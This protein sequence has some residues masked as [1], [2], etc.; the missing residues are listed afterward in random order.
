MRN[1]RNASASIILCSF[2]LWGC[3][4]TSI[5][6][7][8]ASPVTEKPPETSLEG[9]SHAPMTK[10]VKPTEAPTRAEPLQEMKPKQSKEIS[11]AAL[12]I[13]QD[14]SSTNVRSVPST[15]NNKPIA[16]LKG[17]TAVE[18]VDEKGAWYKIR[19]VDVD[20]NQKEGW[21]SKSRVEK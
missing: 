10:E 16:M 9:I 14:K 3:T 5:P 2:F 20:G 4:A 15:Q 17:G 11:S 18:K 6:N 12:K 21:I 19:F 8:Q 13:K 1:F 7:K